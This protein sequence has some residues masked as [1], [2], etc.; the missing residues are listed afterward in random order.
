MSWVVRHAQAIKRSCWITV[1][2]LSMLIVVAVVDRYQRQYLMLLESQQALLAQRS[3]WGY[4]SLLNNLQT[5]KLQQSMLMANPP[6]TG[7]LS[8]EFIAGQ[9]GPR[10]GRLRLRIALLVR[11]FCAPLKRLPAV[12][13]ELP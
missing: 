6:P 12:D 8:D 4:S 11:K 10:G 9:S 13:G 5:H 3:A 2:V 7:C 1:A